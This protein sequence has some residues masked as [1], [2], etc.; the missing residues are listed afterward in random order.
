MSKWNSY[1]HAWLVA[2]LAGV[3]ATAPVV[4][5]Q[6]PAQSDTGVR[7]T[8]DH[9][10]DAY[11]SEDALQAMYVRDIETDE[12]GR[13]EARGGIFFN[14]D[15]DLIGIIDGM[16]A[17][18]DVAPNRRIE[19]HV[20]P[21]MYAAFLNNENEDIFGIGV[22]GQARYFFNRS[23]TTSATLSLFYVPDIL[24][25]GAADNVQDVTLRLESQLRDGT[26]IYVGFRAFELDVRAEDR[27]VDD[28]LHLGF[29]RNF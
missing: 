19:V 25:F 4:V 3:V 12:L 15:R 5:A 10:I 17:V 23:R 8:R 14:E 28:N 11:I 29:R 9:A 16:V 13:I 6:Q 21:R 18:G 26:D 2:G 22:G 24:T 1:K 7:V 27:E 20:G